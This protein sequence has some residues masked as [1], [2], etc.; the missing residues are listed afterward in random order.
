MR[1]V[2]IAVAAVLDLLCVGAFVAVGRA[3]HDEAAGIA[4][5]LGTAW[6]FAAGL[7][8]GWLVA[9]AWRSPMRAVW[10]GVLV[11]VV[12]VPLGLALRAFLTQDG[13]PLSFAIVTTVFLG[14]SMVG[15][16]ELARPFTMGRGKG[17][18]RADGRSG[19]N[20]EEAP[21]S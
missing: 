3:S 17:A 8:A 16:R 13:A 10:T 20:G 12:T 11:W 4:G 9:R 18:D 6:P 7:A 1:F 19:G 2:P 14:A 21:A 15:W 5:F